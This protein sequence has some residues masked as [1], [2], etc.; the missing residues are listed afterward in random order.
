MTS[1]QLV[2]EPSGKP[3][4]YFRYHGPQTTTGGVNTFATFEYNF[5]SET[6]LL[7]SMLALCI[8]RFLD[9]RGRRI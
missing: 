3:I 9:A 2:H 7:D 6:L 5:V 1:I 4:G 8:N